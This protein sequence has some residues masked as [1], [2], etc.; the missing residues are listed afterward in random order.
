MDCSSTN[1]ESVAYF[2]NII[3]IR[4]SFR[5]V[6]CMKLQILNFSHFMKIWSNFM[7]WYFTIKTTVNVSQS[8]YSFSLLI[9][10]SNYLKWLKK[11][12]I[13]AVKVV[14]HSYQLRMNTA[15]VHQVWFELDPIKR[16]IVIGTRFDFILWN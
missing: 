16:W 9:K 15:S 11:S 8:K 10:G 12:A 1:F 13:F 7:H 5:W 3:N 14:I 6:F 4:F 2:L